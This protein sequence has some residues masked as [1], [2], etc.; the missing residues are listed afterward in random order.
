MNPSGAPPQKIVSY[1]AMLTLNYKTYI[2]P[3]VV[4]A[5]KA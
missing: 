1:L 2:M 5:E 3:T 4:A